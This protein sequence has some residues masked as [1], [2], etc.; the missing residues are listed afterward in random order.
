[1]FHKEGSSLSSSSSNHG[2]KYKDVTLR[3][4]DRKQLFQS[5]LSFFHIEPNRSHP[6]TTSNDDR[7]IH[8]DAVSDSAIDA[9]RSTS[10]S[11][12]TDDR[13][14]LLQLLDDIFLR[15][16][17]IYERTISKWTI[18]SF[19]SLNS[20]TCIVNV[21]QYYRSP[22]TT[23]A[24]TDHGITWPYS[25]N[26]QC[27]WMTIDI[28]DG[29][30]STNTYHIPG[31]A[32]LSVLPTSLYTPFITYVPSPLSEYICT[33]GVK[34]IMRVGLRSLP[35][36]HSDRQKSMPSASQSPSR[37][38]LNKA[39]LDRKIGR[40]TIVCVQGNPQPMCVG[41]LHPD[42]IAVTVDDM[43][44]NTASTANTIPPLFG[45]GCPK[46]G[47]GVSVV[48]AYGDD[49][50]RQQLPTPKERDKIQQQQHQRAISTVKLASNYIINPIGQ[51]LYDLGHYGNIGFIDGSY[52]EPIMLQQ[53]QLVDG[54]VPEVD[55]DSVAEVNDPTRLDDDAEIE[56]KRMQLEDAEGL[57]DNDDGSAG[58]DINIQIVG[59][60]T[61]KEPLD[62]IPSP[63]EIL[64]DA[65][66][67]ALAKIDIK[68]DLPI[69]MA[70]FYAQFVLPNRKHGT[71][72]QLKQTRYKKFSTYVKEQ[73]DNALLLVGKHVSAN[74]TTDPMGTLIG[75]DRKHPD[76]IPYIAAE[77]E[78]T[79]ALAKAGIVVGVQK[80]LEIADLYCIPNHFVALL[81]LD[82]N[83][84]KA[85]NAKTDERR[86]TG[87][88]TAKE[89]RAILDD[90][91]VEEGLV[92]ASRPDTVMLNG[93]LT[94][95]LYK[96]KVKKSTVGTTDSNVAAPLS[97]Q[98][99]ELVK[100]WMACQESAFALVQT[101]GNVILK[102]KRGKPPTIT[103][104]VSRR[105][106]NKYVTT[107]I[108]LEQYDIILSE[109]TKDVANRFACASTIDKESTS[110]ATAVVVVQ[111]NLS[112]EIEA[113]LLSDE[114][115]TEHGG[116][117]G[118][119]YFLPKN[120][121]HIVL[122]KGVPARKKNQSKR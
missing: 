68:K 35:V 82:P 112:V 118:S 34:H 17:E 70:T 101:P 15:N 60:T 1:M 42:L 64:H 2:K 87:M 11:S 108:G 36:F 91:I 57:H 53:K 13:T 122:K 37:N 79:A 76:L 61:S 66:C 39:S 78:E 75:F 62:Q 63:E 14:A 88:L 10:S 65:V 23:T 100:V 103:I 77:K 98:R 31:L 27:V 21:R 7:S 84:V 72:I 56:L 46:G 28:L 96:K 102:L 54:M 9:S 20:E 117:K 22:C 110:A 8:R 92:D 38:V 67:R 105:Q 95:A 6:E 32:L 50:W 4:S 74:N 52:V 71:T 90:Y 114:T 40:T 104:E 85:M 30:T 58:I 47:I 49:L 83:V 33:N 44:Q 94:D 73:V 25:L 69:T 29:T 19:V 55:Q 119:T 115:L 116:V 89:V 5:V 51:S 24:L 59:G 111:G 99:K 109:F 16:G 80:R 86:G 113:L 43:S 41:I 26:A 12:F 45:P 106:S 120:S 18:S 48:H 81:R 107:V 121:I 93:P 3:K 97:L